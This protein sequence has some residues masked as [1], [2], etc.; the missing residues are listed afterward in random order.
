[1]QYKELQ[2]SFFGLVANMHLRKTTAEGALE[3]QNT[4]TFAMNHYR[5][6]NY[7]NDGISREF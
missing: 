5:E 4:S 6:L 7:L 1:M 2:L 3:L